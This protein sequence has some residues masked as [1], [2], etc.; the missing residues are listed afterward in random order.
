[1]P[2]RIS[3]TQ[4]WLDLIALLLGRRIPLT[5]EEIMERVP[6]YTQGWASEEETA[7]ASVRRMYER[8]KDE[9]R[10]AGIPIE[11]VRYA[12]NFGAEEIEGYRIPRGDYYLPYLRLVASPSAS[13]GPER[14]YAELAGVEMTPSE[15]EA[16]LEALGKIAELPAFPFADEAHSARRK[17]AFDIDPDQLQKDAVLW[18]ERPGTREVLERLR[19]LS[20][21]LLTRK[22]VHFVYHGIHRGTSTERHVAPYGLFYQRDW[23]LVGHDAARDALRVFRIGR[24]DRLEPNRKKPKQPDFEVPP[25]FRLRDYLDRSAWELGEDD[26]L[27]AEVRFAFPRSVLAARNGEGEAVRDEPDGGSVRRFRVSQPDAFLRWILSLGGEAEIIAPDE[28]RDALHVMSHQV[29]ALYSEA[30]HG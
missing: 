25:D 26:G 10:A 22:R 24:M 18:V 1:M 28:L 29:A 5:V 27:E 8:D 11:T 15:A 14:P 2:D 23:Y 21:A 3:K 13:G 19:T 20:D 4:R 12:I 30:A 6:A 16:A 17:L 9:L 7:R